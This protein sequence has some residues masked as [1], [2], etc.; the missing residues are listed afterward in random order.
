MARKRKHSRRSAIAPRVNLRE[1]FVGLHTQMIASLSAERKVISHPT[2]KGDATE[3]HWLN[4]LNEYLP[5]R[6]RAD[7]AFVIDSLGAQSQQIDVIIYDRHYSPFVFNQHNAKYIPAESVYAIFEAK[8]EM[9][10][11]EIEYAAEKAASVRRLH[12]TSAP[13]TYAGGIYKPKKPISILAG[14]LAL[15]SKWVEPFGPAFQAAMKRTAVRGRLDLGC[16]L[17]CGGFEARYGNRQR[18]EISSSGTALIFFFWK[19]L[20]LLQDRGTVA[21]LDFSAYGR[22]L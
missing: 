14:L 3:L 17:K 13:I 2:A 12:R 16:V 5:E 15:D 18:V 22:G 11:Q 8:Q 19:M 9:G 10:S 6:Y 21:A 20:A 1:L 4:L 7:K